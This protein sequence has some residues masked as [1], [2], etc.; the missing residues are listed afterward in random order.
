[1]VAI[2]DGGFSHPSST[3]LNCG[4]AAMIVETV[5]D[6]IHSAINVFMGGIPLWKKLIGH[7]SS[8]SHSSVQQALPAQARR[9]CGQASANIVGRANSAN[10][11]LGRI[12][13]TFFSDRYC[14]LSWR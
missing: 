5:N 2:S 3:A 4:S 14:K 6:A 12:E 10:L 8:P 11:A 13:S 7:Q 9:P 1:M